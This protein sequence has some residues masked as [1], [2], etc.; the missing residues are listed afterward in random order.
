MQ[1]LKFSGHYILRLMKRFR[2]KRR[3]NTRENKKI[4]AEEEVRAHMSRQQHFI[5]GLDHLYEKDG[6][7][8]IYNRAAGGFTADQ[9]ANFDESGASFPAVD[10]I[11][12][13]NQNP[14][15][16]QRPVKSDRTHACPKKRKPSNISSSSSSE[17]R[18]NLGSEPEVSDQ[19]DEAQMPSSDEGVDSLAYTLSTMYI[20]FSDRIHEA[21]EASQVVFEDHLD[22]VDAND[23]AINIDTEDT[24]GNKSAAAADGDDDNASLD[25]KDSD[26]SENSET[27]DDFD[28]SDV[29]SW[30]NSIRQ[31]RLNQDKSMMLV[32]DCDSDEALFH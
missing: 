19:V 8:I 12:D 28:N 11:A 9:V 29:T 23:I 3:R 4:P 13:Y 6:T 5:S 32:D 27:D 15:H 22:A 14:G 24:A 25:S 10:G 20:L 31:Q 17:V 7:S 2:L 30:F 16:L 18:S 26:N 21:Q 1:Q